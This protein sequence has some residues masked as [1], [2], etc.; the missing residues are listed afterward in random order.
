MRQLAAAHATRFSGGRSKWTLA[1]R[2]PRLNNHPQHP[3]TSHARAGAMGVANIDL[4]Q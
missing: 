2:G 3:A 1:Q 4:P